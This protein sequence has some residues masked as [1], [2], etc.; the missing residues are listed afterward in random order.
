M[1]IH[2]GG[3]T[4]GHYWIY[5]HD[6]ERKIWR[7]Y[8]DGYVTKVDEAEVFGHDPLIPPATPYFLTYIRN[9]IQDQLIDCVR[10]EPIELVPEH[11]EDTVMEDVIPSV[12]M[13]H[14]KE[15]HGNAGIGYQKREYVPITEW[16]SSN[17]AEL[18]DW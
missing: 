10:R 13:E 14:S 3:A 17:A 4:S 7:K 18:A 5:I 15:M 12:E 16:D 8:N 2:R 9:G 1:F 6:F 11:I